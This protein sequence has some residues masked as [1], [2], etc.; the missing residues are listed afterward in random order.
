MDIMLGQITLHGLFYVI[1][2]RKICGLSL[3]KTDHMIRNR[4]MVIG[5]YTLSD[6]IY[7]VWVYSAGEK[8]RKQANVQA[9]LAFN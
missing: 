4:T 5:E 7:V 3:D 2:H 6:L 8:T 9:K 1:T